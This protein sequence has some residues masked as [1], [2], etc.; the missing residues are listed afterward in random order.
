[1]GIASNKNA[2][3]YQHMHAFQV[4][5]L[6]SLH[7]A[8]CKSLQLQESRVSNNSK[9]QQCS[10]EPVCVHKDCSKAGNVNT[11]LTYQLQSGQ[12]LGLGANLGL[13]F[14]CMLSGIVSACWRMSYHKLV[15]LC[16]FGSLIPWISLRS[17]SDLLYSSNCHVE[18]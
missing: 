2:G 16:R 6:Q 14:N 7:P 8:Q 15:R 12:V 11:T 17:P 1:M 4:Q 10:Q 18:K 13:A 9:R 5:Q 3:L